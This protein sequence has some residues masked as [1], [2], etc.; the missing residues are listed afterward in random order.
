MSEINFGYHQIGAS[1]SGIKGEGDKPWGTQG[2]PKPTWTIPSNIFAQGV[3]FFLGRLNEFYLKV[4]EG[5]RDYSLCRKDMTFKKYSCALFSSH[6]VPNQLV[7]WL[8]KNF[9]LTEI[10]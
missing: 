3:D 1:S 8:L 10:K 4:L 2:V 6:Y 7:Q 5:S 9:K